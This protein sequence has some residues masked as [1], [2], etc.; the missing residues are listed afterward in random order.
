MYLSLFKKLTFFWTDPMLENKNGKKK[1]IALKAND[2]SFNWK[3]CSSGKGHAENI[4]RAVLSLGL[5]DTAGEL[6]IDWIAVCDD[7]KKSDLIKVIECD[8]EKAKGRSLVASRAKNPYAVIDILENFDETIGSRWGLGGAPIKFDKKGEYAHPFI[9]QSSDS[10]RGLVGEVCY[11]KSGGKVERELNFKVRTDPRARRFSFWVKRVSG[12]DSVKLSV[13]SSKTRHHYAANVPLGKEWRKYTFHLNDLVYSGDKSERLLPENISNFQFIA[14]NEEVRFLID[15]LVIEGNSNMAGK[16]LFVTRPLNANWSFEKDKNILLEYYLSTAAKSE[17]AELQVSLKE[18][19][20]DTLKKSEIYSI[21]RGINRVS[22]DIGRF[23][24]GYY[25]AEISLFLDG[26]LQDRLQDNFIVCEFPKN[27]GQHTPIGVNISEKFISKGQFKSLSNAGIRLARVWNFGWMEAEPRPGQWDFA[28]S[29]KIVAWAKDAKIN[30]LPILQMTPSWAMLPPNP[31]KTSP[32][33]LGY[34]LTHRPPADLKDWRK[35]VSKMVERY[36]GYVKCW[37]IWNEPD[38]QGPF[39]YYFWGTTEEYLEVLKAAYI[40]AKKI[41]KNC[42]IVSGGISMNRKYTVRDF[43]RKLAG[44]GYSKYM[45]IYGLH[46]YIAWDIAKKE[47]ETIRAVKPGAKVWQTEVGTS[48]ESGTPAEIDKSMQKFIEHA[49]RFLEGGVSYYSFFTVSPTEG[50]H[51]LLNGNGSP[52]GKLAGICVAAR[53]LSGAKEIKKNYAGKVKYY[54]FNGTHGFCLAAFGPGKIS[55]ESDGQITTVN[56]VGF[57]SGLG[58]KAGNFKL[59]R[60]VV[61]FYSPETILV[62]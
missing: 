37:E 39:A 42:E 16:S 27:Y 19:N 2:G 46:G 20:G 60:E 15:D 62:K 22:I 18:S 10:E 40:E 24:N 57:E 59:A 9:I 29:D 13:Y 26:K 38:W 7:N 45:D 54:T 58:S 28:A 12:A 43:T 17:R 36:N 56:P 30:I 11:P 47:I 31:Q 14:H 48:G 6:D 25:T 34:L 32:P 53:I 51:S 21:K 52:N 4:K 49:F 33:W 61:Y 55:L 3:I 50:K 41:D 44:L 1:Y 35:Y 5:Q 8:A 23:K